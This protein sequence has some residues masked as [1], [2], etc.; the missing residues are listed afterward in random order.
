MSA[1]TTRTAL[2]L[3]AAAVVAGAGLADR[4]ETA[5]GIERPARGMRHGLPAAQSEVTGTWNAVVDLG[6]GSGE[7][8]FV[9]QQ[10]GETLTGTYRGAFG[11]AG[12]TGTVRGRRIQ[13]T[14]QA[15]EAEASYTG[16]ITQGPADMTMDGSCDYGDI[17]AG[18][19]SAK[20]VR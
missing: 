13:F 3:V 14:F 20:K 1:L 19:W 10:T 17:G 11:S 2:V 12:I 18:T 7:V 9:L 16:R 8:E 4:G 15:E 6:T 5:G